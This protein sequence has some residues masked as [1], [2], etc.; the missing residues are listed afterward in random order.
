[1]M[2]ARLKRGLGMPTVRSVL[3]V[4]YSGRQGSGGCFRLWR[5]SSISYQ[6]LEI[7]NICILDIV[8]YIWQLVVSDFDI[9]WIVLNISMPPSP[10]GINLP[11]GDLRTWT[12]GLGY[13]YTHL[14]FYNWEMLRLSP[15]LPFPSA[16]LL[17]GWWH[18][19]WPQ[20]C[21]WVLK[22]FF[23]P[24]HSCWR[25]WLQRIANSVGGGRQLMLQSALVMVYLS[26]WGPNLPSA[27]VLLHWIVRYNDFVPDLNNQNSNLRNFVSSGWPSC[28]RF[29]RPKFYC[30]NPDIS[31]ILIMPDEDFSLDLYNENYNLCD[32]VPAG[33]SL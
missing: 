6:V 20:L 19:M 32:I 21:S 14:S 30:V 29:L 8:Q 26:S 16:V 31:G 27:T 13:Q 3:V 22:C 11:A 28:S 12:N 24:F 18:W 23:S 2:K 10:Q 9:L 33:L 5:L 17:N 4:V 7:F 1:M 25:W 15:Y